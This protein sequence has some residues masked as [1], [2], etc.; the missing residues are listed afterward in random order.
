M[1]CG[2]YTYDTRTH[3]CCNGKLYT[4]L[5]G[6][7]CCGDFA[8]DNS[9]QICCFDTYMFSRSQGDLCCGKA[10]YNS[11]THTCC[12]TSVQPIHGIK[13][14]K[15]WK[16]L[17]CSIFMPLFPGPLPHMIVGGYILILCLRSGCMD[18]TS[19]VCSI[20]SSV[21]VLFFEFT[22]YTM[23]HRVMHTSKVKVTQ[24]KSQKNVVVVV[25]CFHVRLI[26]LSFFVRYCN[27]LAE[28]LITM[29]RCV[30]RKNQAY[31]FLVT[32][33]G[34]MSKTCRCDLKSLTDFK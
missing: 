29:R 3:T 15:G 12:Q 4:K 21:F 31:T 14:R 11:S 34:Q 33:K 27:Y 30:M 22:F 19:R 26:T 10:V 9:T 17:T 13:N 25:V 2:I 6:S 7:S 20:S 23:R 32:F 8:Y 28:M 5:E 16:R 18:V 24:V 1:C